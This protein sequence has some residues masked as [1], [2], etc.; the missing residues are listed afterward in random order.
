MKQDKFRVIP[1]LTNFLQNHGQYK[2]NNRM[3]TYAAHN[4]VISSIINK[5]FWLQDS[6]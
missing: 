1:Y 4:P 2:K 6:S 5:N 3:R